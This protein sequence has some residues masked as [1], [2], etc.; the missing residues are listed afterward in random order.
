M[1]SSSTND[2]IVIAPSFNEPNDIVPLNVPFIALPIL[3]EFICNVPSVK[4]APV[5]V[6][7]P[8]MFWFT[9]KLFVMSTLPVRLLFPVTDKISPTFTFAFA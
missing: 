2:S 4:V 9:C 5:I 3:P 1:L 6:A 8:V 7:F